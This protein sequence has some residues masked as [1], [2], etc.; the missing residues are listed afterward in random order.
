MNDQ[1]PLT[2]EQVARI[3]AIVEGVYYDFRTFPS[4]VTLDTADAGALCDSHETLRALSEQQA[5]EIDRLTN[6]VAK[7]D[8][9]CQRFIATANDDAALVG[10]HRRERDTAR[11]ALETAQAERDGWQGAAQRAEALT[12]KAQEDLAI[13][14]GEVDGPSIEERGTR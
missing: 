12:L 5:Q 6:D 2:V 7:L 3:R 4:T 8:V 11:A 13:A 10:Q 1:T 9:A 14:R